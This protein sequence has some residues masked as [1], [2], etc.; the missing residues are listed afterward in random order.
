MSRA[1][2]LELLKKAAAVAVQLGMCAL[3]FIVLRDIDYNSIVNIILQSALAFFLP[4]VTL[5][6]I[7]LVLGKTPAVTASVPVILICLLSIMFFT[8]WLPPFPLSV[9]LPPIEIFSLLTVTYAVCGFL[10]TLLNYLI[11]ETASDTSIP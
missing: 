3:Q 7:R 1:E 10:P 8:G 11:R 6:L 5:L 9:S 2:K 4:S